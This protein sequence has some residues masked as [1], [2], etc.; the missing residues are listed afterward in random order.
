MYW[1]DLLAFED[2]KKVYDDFLNTFST[3]H[4]ECSPKVETKL[5]IYLA[6]LDS[7]RILKSSKITKNFWKKELHK[8]KPTLRNTEIYLKQVNAN[9]KFITI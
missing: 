8:T 4:N 5:K 3:Y 6:S 7:K 9:L 1:A 2:T